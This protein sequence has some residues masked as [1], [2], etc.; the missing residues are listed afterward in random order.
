MTKRRKVL[1]GF[2][3]KLGASPDF[4]RSLMPLVMDAERA[5][6]M[7]LFPIF[8]STGAI[9]FSRNELAYYADELECDDLVMFD[10]DVMHGPEVLDRLLSFDADVVA[11]IYC[12]RRPGAPF[13]LFKPL[14]GAEAAE[15]GLLEC[16]VIATGA[17][18]IKVSV[19]RGIRD[20]FPEREFLA[21]DDNGPEKLMYE[22]FPMGV[23]GPR[24]AE[25]RLEKVKE[26]LARLPKLENRRA[27]ITITALEELHNA[28][29]GAQPAGTIMG[30]DYG[31]CRLARKAGYR[32]WADV[33][34]G[35]LPH[36]GE[37]TFPISIEQVGYR[38]GAP[39]KMPAPQKDVA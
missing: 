15:N 39:I 20:K 18:R 19:L 29:H 9:N 10:E 28:V 26:A 33:G 14:P 34:G 17:M 12:K 37:T 1:L 36:I 6:K 32:V 25:S 5:K 11:G 7:E 31:F 35:I 30:E 8:N 2:P 3:L 13:W 27:T 23:C 38:E 21:L 22:W 4:M 16:S 24:T